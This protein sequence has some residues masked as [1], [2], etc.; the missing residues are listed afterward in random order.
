MTNLEIAFT[1][2]RARGRLTAGK[3]L[4]ALQVL[5]LPRDTPGIAPLFNR[6]I[7]IVMQVLDEKE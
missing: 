4:L 7:K 5:Q 3:V 6:A 1:D 2:R